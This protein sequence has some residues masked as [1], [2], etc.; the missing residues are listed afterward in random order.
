MK[1][2]LIFIVIAIISILL[3]IGFIDLFTDLMSF[4]AKKFHLD[5]KILTT[6]VLSVVLVLFAAIVLKNVIKQDNKN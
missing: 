6:I 4:I 5:L 3:F 2:S 1:N